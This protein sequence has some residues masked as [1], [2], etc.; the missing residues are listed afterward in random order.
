[1]LNLAGRP[2]LYHIIE[3]IKSVNSIDKI[4]LAT[5]T[6]NENK[7][8]IDLAES[9]GINTFIGSVDNV[10]ERYYMASN[11]F[12][13]DYIMRVTGDNPFADPYYA[14]ITAKT[15]LKR[16]P[17]LCSI[18]NLPLG[19]AVEIIKKDALDRAYFNSDTPYHFEHVSPYI[20][21]N[22]D[23]FNIQRL[24]ADYFNPF[25]GLRL[26]IDTEEDYRLS[27]IIYDKLYTS[28][29]FPLLSVINFLNENPDLV[30][31]N[32]NIRQRGMTE[33]NKNL[34]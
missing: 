32:S 34:T 31:I 10:L 28:A 23:L 17:D 6:G 9:M 5:G 27:K 2:I 21:E 22:K 15:S 8:L 30:N 24:S 14:E 26:T 29:P 19:I 25:K 4:V 33:C 1:M 20:K 11:E 16:K 7:E 18:T 12:G 13:G 3:R